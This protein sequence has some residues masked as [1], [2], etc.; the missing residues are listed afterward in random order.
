LQEKISLYL[1]AKKLD[2]LSNTT[3]ENYQTRA[4]I[5][6]DKVKK[7]TQDITAADIRVYLRKFKSFKM[8]TIGTKLSVLKSFFSWLSAEEIIPK[9]PTAKLKSPKTEK[10]LPKALTHRRT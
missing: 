5:F 2:G 4:S 9:D 1:S 6:S 3:I 10:R 8:S 7:K